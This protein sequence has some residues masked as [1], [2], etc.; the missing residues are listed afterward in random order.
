MALRC[1]VWVGLNPEARS[2][3]SPNYQDTAVNDRI[4]ANRPPSRIHCEALYQKL[5]ID[6]LRLP[7]GNSEE[8]NLLLSEYRYY[9]VELHDYLK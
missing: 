6:I 4:N 8:P 2:E 5:R 9:E 3:L 1:F 7:T